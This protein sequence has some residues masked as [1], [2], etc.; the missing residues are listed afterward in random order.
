MYQAAITELDDTKAKKLWQ[1]LMHYGYDTMWI[2][3]EL[4]EV[5]TYFAVGPNVGAFTS[6]SYINIWD[7]YARYSAQG[8][9]ADGPPVSSSAGARWWCPCSG[10]R[11]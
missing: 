9:M 6:R 5:P 11:C 1:D 8:I 3:V 4:V 7:S 10:C 2:N